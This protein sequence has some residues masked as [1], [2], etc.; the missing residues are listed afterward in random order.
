MSIIKRPS[1]LTFL[2]V[3][4]VSGAAI[5]SRFGVKIPMIGGHEFW[6]LLAAHVLLVLACLMRGL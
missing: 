5:A 3:L 6:M 2:I 4:I 1:T